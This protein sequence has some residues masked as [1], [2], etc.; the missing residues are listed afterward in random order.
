MG[1]RWSVKSG[2]WTVVSSSLSALSEHLIRFL[3][4]SSMSSAGLSMQLSLRSSF[5]EILGSSGL[6]L[7]RR[8]RSQ[9][10]YWISLVAPS[11]PI[12]LPLS[13]SSP[14]KLLCENEP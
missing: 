4:S 13:S 6:L 12:L 7:F 8:S 11:L 3:L 5:M 9:W 10:A 14:K 1:G 2:R